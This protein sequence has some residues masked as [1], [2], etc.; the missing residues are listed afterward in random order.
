MKKVVRTVWIS[1]LTGLAFLVACHA[2]N[3]LTR[4]E[5]KQLKAERAAIEAEITQPV[6]NLSL[7]E[8][9]KHKMWE[10][11][12]LERIHEI[13][14]LL[15]DK[16][17]TLKSEAAMNQVNSDIISIQEVIK[18][19]SQELLYGPPVVSNPKVE[20]MN[21]YDRLINILKRREG[22]CVYGSPEVIK[23]YGQETDSIRKRAQ[24][25]KKQLDEWD[26]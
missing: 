5:K 6:P 16:D 2:Q 22:A 11:T 9:L 3:H 14:S 20:L 15:G 23:R 21:E 7:D 25:I 4:A 17:E 10:L 12:R 18:G 13:N 24:E 26:Q 1:M 8:Q 19:S